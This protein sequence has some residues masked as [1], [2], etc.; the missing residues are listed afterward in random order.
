MTDYATRDV[1]GVTAA[2]HETHAAAYNR[3]TAK[4][5]IG[6][7]TDPQINLLMGLG[8][9]RETAQGYSKRQAS[10][11]IQSMKSKRCTD[12]QRARLERDGFTN[13]QIN[14]MNFDAA[15]EAIDSS[16]NTAA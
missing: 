2:G 14:G 1:G 5:A 15:S 12:R 7:A 10:A 11:V 6:G 16:K 9:R 4:V 13:E 8:V 3:A